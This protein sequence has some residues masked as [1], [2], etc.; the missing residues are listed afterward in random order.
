A[1]DHVAEGNVTW[2]LQ[3][4]RSTGAALTTRTLVS[5]DTGTDEGGLQGAIVNFDVTAVQGNDGG[6][7]QTGL[8]HNAAGSGSLQWTDLGGQQ[9]AAISWGNGTAFGGNSFNNRT[10]DLSNYGTITIRISADDPANGGGSVGFN[11][12]FQKN[13]FQFENAEGGA[14]RNIII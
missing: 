13:N 4:V 6:Q 1:R 2:T 10:T 12:F 5:H 11:A 14:G 8:S 3:E 9:G 7:N